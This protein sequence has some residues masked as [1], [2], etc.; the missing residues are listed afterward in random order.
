MAPPVSRYRRELDRLLA[1]ARDD[2]DLR[3]WPAYLRFIKSLEE[4]MNACKADDGPQ[5]VLE[6]GLK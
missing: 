1:C 6:E 5:A 3:N 2:P 4:A